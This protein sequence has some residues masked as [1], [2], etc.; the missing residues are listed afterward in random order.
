VTEPGKDNR[1]RS[2]SHVFLAATLTFD[3]AK[4]PVNLRNLSE[5]GALVAGELLPPVGS[6]IQFHRN[7]L[8]VQG[9]VAWVREQHAGLAFTVPISKEAVLSHVP[10]GSLRARSV[11]RVA[12]PGVRGDRLTPEEKAMMKHWGWGSK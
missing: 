9:R 11:D 7:E 10:A 3:N 2:R 12:R 6:V 1:R 8:T 4:L 5:D